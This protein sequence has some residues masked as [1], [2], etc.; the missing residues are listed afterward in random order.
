MGKWVPL[1][2]VIVMTVISA[3]IVLESVLTRAC[4]TSTLA[5]EEDCC[6]RLASGLFFLVI[7]LVSF[8]SAAELEAGIGASLFCENVDENVLSYL[9]FNLANKLN[10]SSGSDT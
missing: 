6:L 8:I 5:W 7:L 4:G 9:E 2:P 3:F 1:L 10:V